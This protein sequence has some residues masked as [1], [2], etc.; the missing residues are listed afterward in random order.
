MSFV[1]RKSDKGVFRAIKR[2]DG[3]YT[4]EALWSGGPRLICSGDA[5]K[6]NF[7]SL[8][9]F[10]RPPT[11]AEVLAGESEKVSSLIWR[12]LKQRDDRE[13]EIDDDDAPLTIIPSN[14]ITHAFTSDK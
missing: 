11:E 12:A 5:L 9:R 2:N 7:Q 6:E 1:R 13:R 10:W 4:L 3:G 14:A 8:P